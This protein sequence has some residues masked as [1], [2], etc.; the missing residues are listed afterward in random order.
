MLPGFYPDGMRLFV[1]AL[2][3]GRDIVAQEGIVVGHKV[4]HKAIEVDKAKIETL[5]KLSPPTSVKA[6]RS[7]LGNAGLY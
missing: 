3:S 2:G 1:H 6:I 4:S 5:E 7:F